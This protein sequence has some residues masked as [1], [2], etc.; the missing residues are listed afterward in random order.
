MK[1]ENIRWQRIWGVVF[2]AL[3]VLI[4]ALSFIG[5]TSKQSEAEQYR[6]YLKRISINPELV[7]AIPAN[8]L[9]SSPAMK[10]VDALSNPPALC[11]LFVGVA[12][13][14]NARKKVGL[15]A[16]RGLTVY[17]AL[18]SAGLLYA[19]YIARGSQV[20][21]SSH[22]MMVTLA[23]LIFLGTGALFFWRARKLAKLLKEAGS[24][25]GLASEQ[26][27]TSELAP[28]PV[29]CS[30]PS[31]QATVSSCNIL[32]LAPDASRLWQFDAKGGGFAL[33]HEHR[34]AIDEPLPSRLVAKSWN[35]LWQPR[36]NV[37]WLPPENVFLRVIEL[38]RSTFDETFA[39]VELQLEKLSP[40][41][42][43]QIVWTIHILSRPG[44]PSPQSPAGTEAATGEEKKAEDLQTVVVVIAERSSVEQFL[45]RLEGRGYLADRLEVPMLDQLEAAT[46]TEDGAWIYPVALS[47]QSA[48]LVAW[49]SGGALRN[50]GFV[51][52]P[53]AGDRAKNLKAQLAQLTWAG[54]LE[55]WLTA[56]PERWHLVTDPVNA[57]DWE[58]TLREGLGE[59]V[60]VTPP[61]PPA[62]LASHTARRAAA[63]GSRA[64]LL[65]AEFPV[66]YHQQ[67]VDRLW[68]RGLVTT[69]VLYAIGVVIYFCAVGLLTFQTQKVENK[70][71]AISGSYTNVQQLK[72]RLEVVKQRQELKYAA[73]DCLKV[74][75]EE[76]PVGIALQRF[77]FVGGQKLSLS[78]TTTPEQINLLYD[79]EKGAHRARIDNQPVFSAGET[80]IWSQK[81]NNV[82]WN[83]NL[84][85]ER[86]E[87][88]Q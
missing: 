61:L 64:P 62:E 87:A 18:M 35:S 30:R 1:H 12:W 86:R 48:A 40:V 83:L 9:T 33:N 58:K 25:A 84:Q 31:R 2:I 52:L 23:A 38:P 57:A 41:P 3:S 88:A 77:S 70:V 67:F 78:G 75:A 68:L 37:A 72:A 20:V 47:G 14:W 11:F 4:Y 27:H 54:E 56:A 10:V 60:Q 44:K 51:I 79:F 34:A 19:I 32:Q 42:V 63:A 13:F 73:L 81:N 66:R 65:P 24:D 16:Y 53:P 28:V 46:P 8:R 7:Q 50:L 15:W 74:V 36:L 26:P 69:G 21:K 29:E 43:T 39:M 82:T 71:A 6:E 49:W 17:F 80:P 59:P 22:L 55:G 76:L 45:G 5:S 85:L